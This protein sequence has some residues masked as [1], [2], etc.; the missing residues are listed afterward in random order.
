MVF[1]KDILRGDSVRKNTPKRS[2]TRE[3]RNFS[4]AKKTKKR[5]LRLQK[6]RRNPILKPVFEHNWE[7]YQTFNP[8]AL[9]E[10]GKVHLFYRA[11][12]ED[13]LSRLGY[14]TSKDGVSIDER[15]PDPVFTFYQRPEKRFA[16]YWDLDYVSGGGWGG[17][18]DPRITKIGDT[19]H[20]IFVAFDGTNPPR[21]ALS[22][23]SISDIL[24]K[25]W[26][27]GGVK[28]IS[29]PGI[30]DKSGCLFPEK[31]Q[32]KYAILHRIFPHIYMDFVDNLDF[33]DG[34]FLKSE[35]VIKTR[36]TYWDSRKI[37]AGAP[38]IKTPYGWLLIYYGVDERDPSKYKVGA[39]LLDIEKPYKVL[40]RTSQPILEP[41]EW[42]ETEGHKSGVVYPCGAIVNGGKLFVYYGGA[43]TVVCAASADFSEFLTSLWQDKTPSLK[44]VRSLSS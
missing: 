26:K 20:M 33:N 32:G 12:G 31:I 4:I 34:Q 43:D 39:M 16:Q 10:D 3:R 11:L 24:K 14:A 41:M 1:L 19:A 5:K 36:K 27:W 21:L 15:Y 29:A 38:P 28:F 17:S 13:G 22:S 25:K 30:V 9:V 44:R 40:R 42:Y 23:I 8:A 35:H 37:G 18:E 2:A 6:S 7:A